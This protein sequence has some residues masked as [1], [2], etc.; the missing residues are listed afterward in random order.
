MS[1][2]AC[3]LALCPVLL[4]AGLML[5]ARVA[6]Q[7]SGPAPD[8]KPTAAPALP[9]PEAG[10]AR[11]N[12]AG[13]Q[14]GAAPGGKTSDP[15]VET[16]AQ[17]KSGAGEAAPTTIQADTVDW[18]VRDGVLNEGST[19]GGASGLLRTQHAQASAPGQFRLGFTTEWFSAG[20]LCTPQF[21]CPN[22]TGAAPL[23]SYTV[24]NICGR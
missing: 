24:S 2:F 3:S 20:F 13:T 19:L 12:P 17:A 11:Q 10:C 15:F 14:A 5:P 1:R 6:A 18:T 8:T 23:T 22:P 4:V 16:N 21:P 9:A 7:P